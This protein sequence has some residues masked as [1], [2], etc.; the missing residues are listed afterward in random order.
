VTLDDV[1][2][3]AVVPAMALLPRRMDSPEAR[4]MLLAIGLQESGFEHRYQLV[5]GIPNVK[6]PARGFWQF[7]RGGGARGVCQHQS[8]RR[9]TSSVCAARGVKFTYGALW[10]AL[11]HDDVLACSAARL[12]LFTD[13]LPLPSLADAGAAWDLYDRVWRPG[14][15]HPDR[16]PENHARAREQVERGTT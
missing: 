12:L 9:W 10:L 15:P 13:P 5:A 14:K 2:R 7:E 6:G 3:K 16:W 4:T 11:E 8:V 1:V